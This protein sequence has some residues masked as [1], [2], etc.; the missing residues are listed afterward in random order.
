MTSSK[1]VAKRIA[2]H[3]VA[4]GYTQTKLAEIVGVS[5]GTVQAWERGT[6][7][8]CLSNARLLS[9]IFDAQISDFTFENAPD[10]AKITPDMT[11]S[12]FKS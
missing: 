6:S 4:A 1:R 9:K 5:V 2:S 3:R 12:P 11:N 8:P 7:L 10:F